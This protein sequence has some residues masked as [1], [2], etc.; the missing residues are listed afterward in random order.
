MIFLRDNNNSNLNNKYHL[1]YR[2]EGN[3][4]LFF[5]FD[6]FDQNI[7]E[8][9]IQEYGENNGILSDL[10]EPALH[11]I[12]KNDF[13]HLSWHINENQKNNFPKSIKYLFSIAPFDY[14]NPSEI[15]D[16][17]FE[18]KFSL[19]KKSFDRILEIKNMQLDI[20][21]FFEKDQLYSQLIA[22]YRDSIDP[23]LQQVFRVVNKDN[24]E[25]ESEE[26][27]E[28]K[29][30]LL[31]RV[32]QLYFDKFPLNDL[33]KIFSFTCLEKNSQSI[34]PGKELKEELQNNLIFY[35]NNF[36]KQD[37]LPNPE[38]LKNLQQALETWFKK[39]LEKKNI[40]DELKLAFLGYKK[41]INEKAKADKEKAK[42]DKE[43][44]DKEKADKDKLEK[45][46]SLLEKFHSY[47]KRIII[48][49]ALASFAGGYFAGDYFAGPRTIFSSLKKKYLSKLKT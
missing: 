24:D 35:F 29:K 22:L 43:N 31:G 49:I 1:N 48:A 10:I 37:Q 8:I 26:E 25:E 4:L 47:D 18:E 39:Q 3:E 15:I 12:K 34:F 38:D 7:T 5:S 23:F 32:P 9:D 28:G 14:K 33:N 17:N 19:A 45:N 20:A 36:F 13:V 42:A 40:L 41:N 11:A 30:T 27:S 46:K 2:Y 6:T 16:L 21:Q 44:A